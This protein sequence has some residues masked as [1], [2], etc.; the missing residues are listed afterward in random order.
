MLNLEAFDYWQMQAV[1]RV[2]PPLPDSLWLGLF[3]IDQPHGGATIPN[4]MGKIIE[5]SKG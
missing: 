5:D 1:G 2:P 3:T 4:F